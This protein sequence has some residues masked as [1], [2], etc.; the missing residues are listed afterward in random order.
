MYQEP[1]TYI[2]SDRKD[3]KALKEAAKN[4]INKTFVAKD[5]GS[6]E[7]GWVPIYNVHLSESGQIVCEIR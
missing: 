1:K 4:G 3:M 7:E 2:L 6:E 5:P